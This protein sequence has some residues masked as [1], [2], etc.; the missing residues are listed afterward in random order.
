MMSRSKKKMSRDAMCSWVRFSS[1]N[2]ICLRSNLMQPNNS[3]NY[4][5]R[6]DLV[7]TELEAVCVEITKPHSKPFLVTTVYRP[8]SASSELFDHSG[9]LIKA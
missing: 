8:P 9:K 1:C 7:P 4:K 6:N 3:I 5:V 2:L